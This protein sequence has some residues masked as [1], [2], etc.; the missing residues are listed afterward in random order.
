MAR[1]RIRQVTGAALVLSGAAIAVL[2]IPAAPVPVMA[3]DARPSP[4]VRVALGGGTWDCAALVPREAA[5]TV[6]DVAWVPYRGAA[7]T[8]LVAHPEGSDC[9][10][11]PPQPVGVLA[12]M[13]ESAYETL[14]EHDTARWATV[15]QV[16]L[17]LLF[18]GNSGRNRLLDLVA[19][20][21][22]AAGVVVAFTGSR[23]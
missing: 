19:A 9:A 4:G 14:R 15:P 3:D 17:S 8:V 6:D 10:S 16:Q 7:R 18:P 11:L 22:I 5:L 2:A 13:S 21:S 12:H 23:P 20:A 1:R